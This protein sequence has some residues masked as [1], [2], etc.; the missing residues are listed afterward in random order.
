MIEKRR[1]F[2][3]CF[4]PFLLSSQSESEET[5]S[6]GGFILLKNVSIFVKGAVF[7]NYYTSMPF[8]FWR[9]AGD[10]FCRPIVE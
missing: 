6:E 10:H 9:L 5:K 3:C 4:A 2:E 7:L 1:A 8:F